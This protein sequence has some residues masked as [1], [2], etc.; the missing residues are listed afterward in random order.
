MAPP[1]TSR[2]LNN[3]RSRLPGATDDVMKYELFTTLDEFFKESSVW[4][5]ELELPVEPGTKVYELD[6]PTYGMTHRLMWVQDADE[7]LVDAVLSDDLSSV[8]LAA[9][10]GAETTYTVTVA[11]TVKDPVTRESLPLCPSWVIDKYGI[12]LLDGLLGRMMSQPAK[13]YSS[14]SL[15][16]LHLRRFG[17]T[18]ALARIEGARKNTYGRQ[19]W[20]FPQNFAVRRK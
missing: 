10:P 17:S 5:E 7:R 18:K 4:K 1:S 2:L 16:V 14:E 8:E 19:N 12:G 11:V 15:A 20:S 9:E 3:A 13:P 6:P